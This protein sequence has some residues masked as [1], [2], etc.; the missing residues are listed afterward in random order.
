MGA[1]QVQQESQCLKGVGEVPESDTMDYFLEYCQDTSNSCGKFLSCGNL[2]YWTSIMLVW[3]VSMDT[4]V[5]RHYYNGLHD[6]CM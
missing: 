5:I 3:N 1:N 6:V 2:M 4:D